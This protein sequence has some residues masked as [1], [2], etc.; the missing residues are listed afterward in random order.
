MVTADYL[1]VF[2]VKPEMGQTFAVE[3]EQERRGRVAV[4]S[5]WLWVRRFGGG[6][7][8]INQTITLDGNSHTIIGVM[9]PQFH[10]PADVE[11]WTPFSL[12]GPPESPMRSRE[13]HFLRPIARLK[14]G[15]TISQA[16]S[17]T[18]AIAGRLEAQYP[19]T[20][21]DFGLHLVPL[22]D[23]IVGD[24]RLTLLVLLGAVG[25]VLLIACVNV[26]SL[27]L[28]RGTSRQREIAVRA[29]LGAGRGRIVRQTLTESLTLALLGSI[30]GVLLGQWGVRVL[31]MLSAGSVPRASEIRISMPVLAFTMAMAVV[32]GLLF[33]LAPAVQS[34]RLEL[35]ESLKESGGL[36]GAGIERHRV[37]RL[38]VIGEVALAV[39]L[40]IGAG[41]L[42]NSL[43]R[44]ERV[45]PGFDESNLLTMRI[46]IPNP[47]A[48]PERKALFFE[49]LQQR[50]AALP[51][52]DAVGLVTELPL[53]GQSADAPF[54]IQGHPAQDFAQS[55]FADIRS[56]NQEYF[57]T[58]RIPVILGRAFTE[59][60]VHKSSKVVIISQELARRYFADEE[61][62][63]KYLRVD[64][65]NKEAFEIIGVVGD[66]RHRGL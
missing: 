61:P 53:A 26:A 32:T 12:D 52:V 8:I 23:R 4:L 29:A 16:Q 33:G 35:T 46:D 48:Q 24:I 17:E 40:L 30:G 65:L 20:N 28:A 21:K 11:V 47:Y 50:V 38:L 42:V 66:V 10:Y 62:V 44:L 22:R 31:V 18:E 57:R 36:A 56:V 63:G 60:E 6:P 14:A 51:G 13:L 41:L 1:D 2:G 25:C 45:R 37:L 15:A 19:K 34:V 9:P 39:V 5:H 43:I 54:N 55:G 3:E 64:L 27:L 49:Q 58:M 59:T 7:S